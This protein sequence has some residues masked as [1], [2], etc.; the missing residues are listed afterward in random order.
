MTIRPSAALLPVAAIVLFFLPVL[1][2]FESV[3]WSPASDFAA[4]DLPYLDFMASSDSLPVRNPVPFA[5][6][7]ALGNLGAPV[8]YPPVA[9]YLAWPNGWWLSV[10]LVGHLVLLALGMYRLARGLGL[11]PLAGAFAGIAVGLGGRVFG[12]VWA[13]HLWL[14]CAWA[15]LPW[16]LHL[17]RQL[18]ARPGRIVPLALVFGMT[19]ATGAL[20]VAYLTVM[21]AVLTAV[22]AAARG[23]RPRLRRLVTSPALVFLAA[24]GGTLAAAATLLPGWFAAQESARGAALDPAFAGA[25]S[26]GFADL[27]GLVLPLHLGHPA[28]GTFR[29]GLDFF[30]RCMTPGAAVVI[31]ALAGLAT[32]GDRR[33]WWLLAGVATAILFAMGN[34]TPIFPVLYRALP[35]LDRFRVPARAMLLALPAVAL[36]AARGFDL[37]LGMTA[38]DRLRL[39]RRVLPSL[40]GALVIATVVW[41][42]F[43]E[44][45][46]RWGTGAAG[47]NLAG[48]GQTVVTVQRSLVFA[49]ALWIPLVLLIRIR[50][51][52]ALARRGF[53]VAV[54]AVMLAEAWLTGGRFLRTRPVA[55]LRAPTLVSSAVRETWPEGRVLDRGGALPP[56]TAQWQGIELVGGCD[57]MVPSRYAALIDLLAGLPPGNPGT[58]L[59]AESRA[60]DEGWRWE[61][62]GDLD[63]NGLITREVV[64]TPGFRR[65]AE[66]EDEERRTVFLYASDAPRWRVR[67]MPWWRVVEGRAAATEAL[68]AGE[69]PVV[70]GG[71]EPPAEPG[72][73]RAMLVVHEPDLYVVTVEGDADA[74]LFVSE[75]WSSAWTATVDGRRAPVRPGD[76]AL[77]AVA[78]PGGTHRV[79]LRAGR[80]AFDTGVLVSL[81]ATSVLLMSVFA[82]GR[83][84]R[85]RRERISSDH[86]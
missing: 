56:A 37:A 50:E 54:F 4:R 8:A 27:P 40:A 29:G 64:T 83:R 11:S 28:E 57:P 51:S 9:V 34:R 48:A 18:P 42:V 59:R 30:E 31:F 25:F 63:A 26:L 74:V 86:S 5:G 65:V 75:T 69:G 68:R 81:V 20:P 45:L 13:G 10:V 62:F 32:P 66:F 49:A 2:A 78:V 7:P 84:S 12:H 82:L 44:P 71:P 61:I 14:I 17:A 38:G 85:R 22:V 1:L 72:R 52:G 43:R 73:G 79:V 53:A 39:S 33:R 80:T 55:E 70:E 46:A 67:R 41:V 21:A 36:L 76:L 60:I 19:F 47:G 24:A 35:G 58:R 15:W 3:A 16:A 77:L 23:E 6:S